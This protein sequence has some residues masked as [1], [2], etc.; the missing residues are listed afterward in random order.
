[1]SFS[2]RKARAAGLV[3]IVL[4]PKPDYVKTLLSLEDP[5][6]QKILAQLPPGAT[7][8]DYIT[9]LEVTARKR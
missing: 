1:M 8:A 5:L 6:Y 2:P 4:N 9:S 3:D 7:A